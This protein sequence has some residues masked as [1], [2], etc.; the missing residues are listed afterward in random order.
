MP[1]GLEWLVVI[2]A[3][4]ILLLPVFFFARTLEGALL[5]V[6]PE[7]R[8][9]RPS[10][11]WWLFVP[12]FGALWAFA[13]VSRF[14]VSVEREAA[15]RGIAKS[16]GGLRATGLIA[17]ALSLAYILPLERW[18]VWHNTLAAT[19]F[20]AVTSIGATVCWILFWVGA[21]RWRGELQAPRAATS[22]ALPPQP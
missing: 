13:V 1:S 10:A 20:E 22:A 14:A 15:A 2:L 12:G 18:S 7:R 5:C 3:L 9:M 8:A 6:A 11:V 4:G 21:A 19:L 16:V 17:A